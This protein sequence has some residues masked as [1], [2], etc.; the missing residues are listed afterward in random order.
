MAGAPVAVEA[1]S[2]PPRAKASS[3]PEPFASRMS[4]REKRPLGDLFGLK[5]F[6]VNRTRLAPGGV[7]ALHHRHTK[8][9]EFV[10]VLEGEPTLVTGAAEVQL[11]PGMCAGFTPDGAAHHLENRTDHDVVV[12]EV[13]DRVAGDEGEYPADDIKAAMGGDG[14]WIFEHKDGTPY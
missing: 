5:A 6:G 10:Y 14:K 4:R 12:L 7:S 3:Y 13:G 9:E 1:A 2:V 8:Q 11:R